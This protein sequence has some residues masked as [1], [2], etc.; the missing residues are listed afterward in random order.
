MQE[1]LDYLIDMIDPY[2]EIHFSGGEPMM[3]EEHYLFL[4][5]L[6][7]RGNTQTKIR[8]NTNLTVYT[9]KDY[10]A[11]EMLQHFDNVFIV[12]SID[13]MG[14]EGEYTSK[15]TG[16]QTFAVGGEVFVPYEDLTND[17][18]VTWIKNLVNVDEIIAFIDADLYTQEN[19]PIQPSDTPLPTNFYLTLPIYDLKNEN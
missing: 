10:N 8:Y 5:L 3:Q 1:D 19:P 11:F 14:T 17:L 2:T 18:V 6:V 16:T 12:G 4:K 15:V 13:A 9:L 7:D